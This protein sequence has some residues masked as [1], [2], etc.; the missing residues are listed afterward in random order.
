MRQRRVVAEKSDHA[1]DVGMLRDRVLRVGL[2]RRAV[3]LIRERAENLESFPG[4]HVARRIEVSSRRSARAA[5]D[6][7]DH[8]LPAPLGIVLLKPP[9][10]QHHAA[11][12]RHRL[13]HEVA[14]HAARLVIVHADV[15]QALA[16]GASESCVM[17]LVRFAALLISSVWFAGSI[18]LTAMPS[19]P[20]VS[21]SS[22]I[23]SDR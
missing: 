4:Q 16:S 23:L 3:E 20:R 5:E 8:A 11:A 15:K 13:A 9:D 21:K 2:A 18:G 14:A 17:T 12:L 22:I 6:G 1:A 10:E 7:I 19:T